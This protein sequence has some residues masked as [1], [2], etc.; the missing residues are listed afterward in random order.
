MIFSPAKVVLAAAV[1]Q[2]G[3]AR[4]GG[5]LRLVHRGGMDEPGVALRRQ[6]R[7]GRLAVWHQAVVCLK[8]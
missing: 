3:V 1:G 6:Q 5:D 8:T 4:Q 7:P 2:V